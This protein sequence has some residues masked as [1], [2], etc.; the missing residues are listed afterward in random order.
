MSW[1]LFFRRGALKR[2]LLSTL[3]ALLVFPLLFAGCATVHPTVTKT[4]TYRHIRAIKINGPFIVHINLGKKK[5]KVHISTAA[6]DQADVDVVEH[7]G[8]LTVSSH[9]FL[10]AHPVIS[11]DASRNLSTLIVKRAVR[12]TIA[13]KS[14]AHVGYLG[15]SQIRKSAHLSGNMRIDHL[16]LSGHI[17][18]RATGNF[19]LKKWTQ[20]HGT[21]QV[22]MHQLHARTLRF[23]IMGHSRYTLSGDV[24][25]LQA[26]LFQR[27]QLIAPK[28]YIKKALIKA[29]GNSF[30]KVLV[31]NTLFAYTAQKGRI[32]Y[33]GH[34]KT[35][36]R[37]TMQRS[38]IL[39]VGSLP[40]L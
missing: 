11:I 10:H 2:S 34:P 7:N 24:H 23:I 16:A 30:A 12:V 26:D 29:Q 39:P 33:F 19:T 20:F 18:L 27:A 9:A 4:H 1:F 5:Q 8:L 37:R 6:V 21:A 17:I 25:H 28:L 38:A 32:D 22:E 3:V 13:A 36:Y 35:L 31:A 15:L 14:A 40:A